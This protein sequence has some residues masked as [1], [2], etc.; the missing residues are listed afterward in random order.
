MHVEL[1][2]VAVK[3]NGVFLDTR[4][5]LGGQGVMAAILEL[6]FTLK[7]SQNRP[8]FP[9]NSFQN[10]PNFPQ[11]MHF[12]TMWLA[13]AQDGG[14][15]RRKLRG[16]QPDCAIIYKHFTLCHSMRAPY[17][18][19][20]ECSSS[21][22]R[23]ATLCTTLANLNE[24]E[25][26][27]SLG[28]KPAFALRG[29][30]YE[31]KIHMDDV[32]KV[33]LY[34]IK[35]MNVVGEKRCFHRCNRG[36]DS[37]ELLVACTHS[38]KHVKVE[39][40]TAANKLR[41]VNHGPYALLPPLSYF[42][43]HH[44]QLWRPVLIT[45][46]S[47]ASRAWAAASSTL[48]QHPPDDLGRSVIESLACYKTVRANR[49]GHSRLTR[50]RVRAR[51]SRTSCL[52]FP[53]APGHP[54]PPP[55]A[56]QAC[57]KQPDADSARPDGRRRDEGELS[58]DGGRRACRP[59]DFAR[60]AHVFLFDTNDDRREDKTRDKPRLA[61]IVMRTN[62]LSF[63]SNGN[64]TPNELLRR[65]PLWLEAGHVGGGGGEGR[66]RR[67]ARRCRRVT[68]AVVAALDRMPV[69]TGA[70]SERAK[71]CK[72][73]EG[74]SCRS[75]L[76]ALLTLQ[77]SPGRLTCRHFMN[78][79]EEGRGYCLRV[80]RAPDESTVT[81]EA[82]FEVALAKIST[83]SSTLSGHGSSEQT[84]QYSVIVSSVVQ[85]TAWQLL[86]AHRQSA[87]RASEN[88]DDERTHVSFDAMKDRQRTDHQRMRTEPERKRS[89]TVYTR[90]NVRFVDARSHVISSC[91]DVNGASLL[92]SATPV[93]AGNARA[94]ALRTVPTAQAQLSGYLAASPPYT[95]Y[96]FFKISLRYDTMPG[97]TK[98]FPDPRL[99][100]PCSEPGSCLILV[101]MKF[102]APTK[103][104]DSGSSIDGSCFQSERSR[105]RMRQ[106]L[107][108]IEISNRQ[109]RRFEMNFISISS[110]D[111][112][113]NGATVFCVDLRS[114]FGSRFDSR[115]G[116][117]PDFRNSDLCRTTSLVGGF[118]GDL[119]FPSPFHSGAAPY[120]SRFTL[121]GSQDLEVKSRP[122][123]STLGVSL[124][125][126]LPSVTQCDS[127]TTLTVLA[128]KQVRL[129]CPATSLAAQGFPSLMQPAYRRERWRFINF[130]TFSHVCTTAVMGCVPRH[131]KR[132]RG[133][134]PDRWDGDIRRVVGVNWK[135]IEQDRLAWK[136]QPM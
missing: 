109:F 68:S 71:R 120:S 76:S 59:D 93:A 121:I 106:I 73:C 127:H 65:G 90:K 58:V 82:P 45:T 81:V 21:L 64:N 11:K 34:C 47:V 31:N 16:S 2:R 84:I 40:T 67:A 37:N 88:M 54:P 96:T 108:L 12:C 36:F 14:M 131:L 17:I 50:L 98:I 112:N 105:L 119:P 132:S 72:H 123:L 122:N 100:Y 19:P 10:Q 18:L 129:V 5:W 20:E 124:V 15:R 125:R 87:G 63:Q 57:A 35:Y 91:S 75:Q 8:N 85:C 133:R 39:N 26:R 118:P 78:D 6:S 51:L 97:C 1:Y 80:S 44:Q 9:Q 61:I 70:G 111:L 66:P 30:K 77:T 3:R 92:A 32:T 74:M 53:R 136:E 126:D 83:A 102:A 49:G 43:S 62:S 56:W 48:Y 28:D 41:C 115:R 86:Q 130:A 25:N 23:H 13:L 110:P 46:Y 89:H 107:L 22:P 95:L 135:N 69:S 128:P 134:P 79:C 33:A 42:P 52:G 55:P 116:R 99:N 113:S 4:C 94:C 27:K 103:F 38:M 101:P 24:K 7:N 114:D 29:R 117:S 60:C 104:H